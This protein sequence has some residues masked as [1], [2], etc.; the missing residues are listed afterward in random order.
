M[1]VEKADQKLQQKEYM[2]RLTSLN[3]I[4]GLLLAVPLVTE[5]VL[6]QNPIIAI[7]LAILIAS[8]FVLLLSF[9]QNR[10]D[11]KY[12]Q[13]TASVKDYFVS[14]IPLYFIALVPGLFVISFNYLSPSLG[15]LTI[16]Y[17]DSVILIIFLFLAK[18]PLALRLGQRATPI[19]DKSL[20]SSFRELANRM[21]VQDVDLYS[22]DWEKFKVAN[23][24]QAGP[25][26]FSIF[27]SNYLI[28][29]MTTEEVQAV[30]AHE[31]AHAKRRHVAK[32][33]ALILGTVMIA[34][35]I[36]IVGASLAKATIWGL[37]PFAIG[38]IMCLLVPR[39]DFRVMKKFEL[40][41]DEIAVKTIGDGNSMI[42][43]L[44]RLAVLNLIP[45][46][47]GSP[48]HPPITKRIQR[49]EQITGPL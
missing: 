37:V 22:I 9:F 46:D 32:F 44:K 34:I 2:S 18:F 15:N 26:K 25:R 3:L 45:G 41:A 23:A 6:W 1:P 21:G 39:L 36:L 47:K 14:N 24:F 16:L 38:F 4:S 43:A 29:N 19:T 10:I 28:K 30:M 7:P 12:K 8:A 5:L 42:S 35:D 33:L 40:E 11:R 49:I 27:V 13:V 31:L 48:T 20:L 17:V